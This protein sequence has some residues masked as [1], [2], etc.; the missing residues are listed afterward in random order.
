MFILTEVE[1]LSEC[2]RVGATIYRIAHTKITNNAKR[3]TF[4]GFTK[5]HMCHSK[6]VCI[7]KKL[8]GRRHFEI[9]SNHVTS[10]R[11]NFGNI[12]GRQRCRLLRHQ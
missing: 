11:C 1:C 3:L 6:G 8:D 2:S 9:D 4:S 10:I 7:L 12:W 5:I